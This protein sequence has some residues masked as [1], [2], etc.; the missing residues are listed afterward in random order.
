MAYTMCI[1]CRTRSAVHKSQG[2]DS[3]YSNKPLPR[4]HAA[5][6][7]VRAH[8]SL[9]PLTVMH[10]PPTIRGNTTVRSPQQEKTSQGC[11]HMYTP[12][13]ALRADAMCGSTNPQG[14]G[15]HSRRGG[16]Q[17]LRRDPLPV[18]RRSVKSASL[19]GR[20]S[21]THDT[22]SAISTG[23]QVCWLQACLWHDT[24][25]INCLR[26]EHGRHMW[27]PR[28][29]KA[30]HSIAQRSPHLTKASTLLH[31]ATYC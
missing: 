5:V 7:T 14:V 25:L 21:R 11:A 29:S 16:F 6:L 22:Q 28:C 15:T 24:K 12:L 23:L 17:T 31:A 20:R 30:Q 10:M 3:A 27:H 19:F 8:A 13:R 18:A 1:S 4:L 9:R 2:M 26:L